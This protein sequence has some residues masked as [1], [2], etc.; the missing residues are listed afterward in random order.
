MPSVGL[1]RRGPQL[2]AHRGLSVNSP[3]YGTAHINPMMAQCGPRANFVPL[4]PCRFLCRQPCN[5]TRRIQTTLP[6]HYLA[7]QL[8]WNGSNQK[9]PFQ[10]LLFQIGQGSTNLAHEIH[11]PAEF[12]YNLNQ[13][14]LSML[15]NVFRIIRKSQLGEFDK[16]WN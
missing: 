12:S 15:I 2:W 6:G 13:T 8:N 10:N 16:S 5:A 11:F 14:H 7:T 9:T 1:P 3:H 4:G